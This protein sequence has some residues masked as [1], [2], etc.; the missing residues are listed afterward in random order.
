M[1]SP[2]IRVVFESFEQSVADFGSIHERI[3]LSFDEVKAV[4]QS[5]ASGW[6]KDGAPA[7]KDIAEACERHF[8]QIVSILETEKQS[9]A[10]A[11]QIYKESD[12]AAGSQF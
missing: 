7:C 10:Q 12:R 11:V 3:G 2:S 9:V 8:Y 4:N 6:V 1:E 5:L